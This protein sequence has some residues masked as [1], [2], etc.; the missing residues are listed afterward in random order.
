MCS[1]DSETSDYRV[2]MLSISLMLL[3]RLTPPVWC[4]LRAGMPLLSDLASR[5]RGRAHERQE[6]HER[7]APD[8][9]VFLVNGLRTHELSEAVSLKIAVRCD[10]ACVPVWERSA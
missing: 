5:T 10:D 6:R 8:L 2:Q 3:M 1:E 4:A 7:H 9:S